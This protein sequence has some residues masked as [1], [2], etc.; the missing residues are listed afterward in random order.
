MNV[1]D[2]SGTTN[3]MQKLEQLWAIAIYIDWGRGLA[4]GH[5]LDKLWAMDYEIMTMK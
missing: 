4:V 1:W 5:I 3:N 2:V